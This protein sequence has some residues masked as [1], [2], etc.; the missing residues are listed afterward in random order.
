MLYLS[1]E[2]CVIAELT[3]RSKLK[4]HDTEK[5]FIVSCLW[6]E[7]LNYLPLPASWWNSILAFF[8]N[9]CKCHVL[10]KTERVGQ[11][12]KER[13]KKTIKSKNIRK[14]SSHNLYRLH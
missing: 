13:K 10:E 8:L 6:S 3:L 9:D 4:F 12:L 7:W 1:C 5:N 11:K 2:F 14:T